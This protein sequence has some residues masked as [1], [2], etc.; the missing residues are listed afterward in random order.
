[1]WKFQTCSVTLLGCHPADSV[2]HWKFGMRVTKQNTWMFF[3]LSHAISSF[4]PPLYSES[5]CHNLEKVRE[6]E[7]MAGGEG[8]KYLENV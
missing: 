6:E 3:S 5:L 8:K 7:T 4:F 1:M 2:I